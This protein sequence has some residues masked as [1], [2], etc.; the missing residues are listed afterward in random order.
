MHCHGHSETVSLYFQVPLDGF[1]YAVLPRQDLVGDAWH[2]QHQVPSSTHTSENDYT[3]HVYPYSTLKIQ[4]HVHPRYAICHIGSLLCIP[5]R[6]L[7]YQPLGDS[8]E[9]ASLYNLLKRCYALYCHWAN[10]PW[11]LHSSSSSS[12][13]SSTSPAPSSPISE[14]ARICQKKGEKRVCPENQLT[15]ARPHKRHKREG[16]R[17]WNDVRSS[18]L[19]WVENVPEG[20]LCDQDAWTSRVDLDSDAGE[21][22][23]L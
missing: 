11:A 18:I 14:I 2:R 13:S 22:G 23:G 8:K 5:F 3:C 20:G 10:P 19:E 6:L 12:S 21:E 1:K 7:Y 15:Q 16:G 4:S 9:S 17:T